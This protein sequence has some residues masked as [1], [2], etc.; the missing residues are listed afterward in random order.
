[1]T[2]VPA[3]TTVATTHGLANRVI[4]PL[5]RTTAGRRTGLRHRLIVL[6]RIKGPTV[7]VDVGRAHRKTWWRSFE[8]RHPIRLRLAGVD[9]DASAV[10]V[11]DGGTVSVVAD[12]E[13]SADLTEQG[14]R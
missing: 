7:H 8:T 4:I 3:S 11:R 14:A 13:P 10:L 5:L 12:L 2:P 6:Y 1:M 9:H